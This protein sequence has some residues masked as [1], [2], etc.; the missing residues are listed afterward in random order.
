MEQIGD[1]LIQLAIVILPVFLYETLRL[2][3]YHVSVPKRN[4]KTTSLLSGGIVALSM[5]YPI[6]LGGHYYFDF[7]AIPIMGTYLY[8]GAYGLFPAGCSVIV[9]WLLYGGDTIW[10]QLLDILFLSS[11]SFWLSRKW[12][13]FANHKKTIISF[14]LAALYALL[15]LVGSIILVSLRDSFTPVISQAYVY[16]TIASLSLAVAMAFQVYLAEYLYD[17]AMLRVEMQK[18]EKLMIV[19]ELAAS[20]AH[21]V[22]NPLT[23][24]RGFI[25]LF[26]RAED[27]KNKEYLELVLTEL[28]RAEHIISDYLNLARPQMEKKEQFCL[29]NLLDEMS[30]IMS[31][32]AAMQG[33]YLQTE[34]QPEIYMLGDHS[35][36]KQAI[37]NIVKNGV[38]AVGDQKGYLK[39]KAYQKGD[40]AVVIVKD[41][42]VGMDKE[43]LARLGQPYYSLKEKGTG[44]GLMVTFSIIQA[45]QG[46]IAYKSEKG[47]GTEATITLPILA[48]DVSE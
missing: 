8:G 14:L 3:R 41:S 33:V 36:L 45:H 18:S 1:L 7:H 16:F 44:L 35:K 40:E 39:V 9:Y 23:V 30:T 46:K 24:V 11:V 10:I 42:G 15:Y 26:Q 2:S 5:M 13:T 47:K 21:E 27:I 4:W 28:D 48:L 25:Q 34:I 38:E 43:Q 17:N 19:S 32:F 29:S 6:H 31:S 12:N 37:M 22:R 20:V